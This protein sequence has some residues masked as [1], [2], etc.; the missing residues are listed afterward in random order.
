MAGFSWSL[1]LFGKRLQ[2]PHFHNP[3][4]C[5]FSFDILAFGRGSCL[6][7]WVSLLIFL[8][9]FFLWQFQCPTQAQIHVFVNYG[10]MLLSQFIL[11]SLIIYSHS[12]GFI[13][14][15]QGRAHILS[16]LLPTCLA[17]VHQYY[18]FL[19]KATANFSSEEIH[20]FQHNCLILELPEILQAS[21]E[22]FSTVWMWTSIIMTGPCSMTIEHYLMFPSSY[23]WLAWCMYILICDISLLRIKSRGKSTHK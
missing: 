1:V 23:K 19:N 9:L 16:V 5:T 14:L 8:Q 7:Q 18:L 22:Y 10:F 15:G 13:C 11:L 17:K 6:H 2:F 3:F 12:A 21:F 20:L 4:S